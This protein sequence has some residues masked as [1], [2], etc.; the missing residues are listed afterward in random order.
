[1]IRL[2]IT[3]PEDLVKD[4]KRIKNKSRY[5]ADALREKFKA[6]RKMDMERTLTEAYKKAAKEDAHFMEEWDG[7]AGDALE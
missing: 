5:I 1:M 3:M 6:E 7:T 2:N 4:L